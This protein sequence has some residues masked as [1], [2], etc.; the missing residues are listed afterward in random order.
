MKVL[1]TELIARD[2]AFGLETDRLCAFVRGE[3]LLAPGGGVP[4]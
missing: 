3:E 1:L 4:L 2:V